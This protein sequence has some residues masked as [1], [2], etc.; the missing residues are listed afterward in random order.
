MLC[1]VQHAHS[2]LI[3]DPHAF[4]K[5]TKTILIKVPHAC[6]QSTM[7][8]SH[9]VWLQT[10]SNILCTIPASKNSIQQTTAPITH[11]TNAFGSPPLI[12]ALAMNNCCSF[13][14]IIPKN[15]VVANALLLTTKI[16]ILF[17][18]TKLSFIVFSWEIKII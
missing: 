12:C 7:T 13:S 18:K 1:R 8:T 14:M 3:A 17:F 10:K 9:K 6:P 4:P 2:S 11:T 15:A 5:S 16:F